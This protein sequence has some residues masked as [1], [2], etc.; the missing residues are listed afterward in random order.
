[1]FPRQQVIYLVE[2]TNDK[3]TDDVLWWNDSEDAHPTINTELTG[4]Q[5]QEL[6]AV[7][8]EYS[9]TLRSSPGRTTLTEHNIDVSTAPPIRLPPYRLPHAYHDSVRAERQ[10]MERSGVIEPSSSEWSSPLVLV[11]KKVGSLRFC[12]DYRCLNTV[13]RYDAYPMP[14]VDELIDQFGNAKYITGLSI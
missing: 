11:K 7:L 14:R 13:A 5:M 1:M 4:D 3:A 12:M 6:K 2:E 8:Q 9:D 10:D